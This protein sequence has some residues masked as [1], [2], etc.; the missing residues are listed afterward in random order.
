MGEVL[1]VAPGLALFGL[2]LL[3]EMPPAG[4][5]SG[6]GVAGHELGQLEQVGYPSGLLQ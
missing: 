6:Q 2:V 5:L 3:S 1:V 4:L